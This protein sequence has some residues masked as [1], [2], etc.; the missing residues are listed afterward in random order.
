MYYRNA[1][2]AI[3]ATTKK[4]AGV[5]AEMGMCYDT[6][7]RKLNGLTPITFDEAVRFKKVVGSELPLEE[8]FKPF[9]G[10]D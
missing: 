8:L 3:N 9:E 7:R 10:A 5:A 4:L 2:Y 1:K 6:L